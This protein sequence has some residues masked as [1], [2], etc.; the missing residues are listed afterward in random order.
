M[1]DKKLKLRAVEPTD[2][3]FI[4][5][6]EADR[7]ATKWSDYMAPFSRY[8]LR[9]YAE[10]YDADPF[11]AGQLRLIVETIAGKPIGIA[12]LYEISERDSKATVGI[13]IHPDFR[14]KGMGKRA[15]QLL[16]DYGMHRLGLG[17]LIAKVSIHNHIAISLFKSAGFEQHCILPSWHKIGDFFH[18]FVLFIK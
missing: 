8:Q 12:D 11:R 13:C 14:N 7:E 1:I 6:C 17:K 18:D 3:E 16:S 2:V 10:T 9:I 5:E 15:I 4:Y